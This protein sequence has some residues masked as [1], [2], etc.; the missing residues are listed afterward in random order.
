MI[1]DSEICKSREEKAKNFTSENSTFLSPSCEE[2]HVAKSFNRFSIIVR[3][4]EIDPR[5]SR[6]N[7]ADSERETC[8]RSMDGETFRRKRVMKTT[9]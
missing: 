1:N 4:M 5:S 8:F 2:C 6:S 9:R 7:V 3:A